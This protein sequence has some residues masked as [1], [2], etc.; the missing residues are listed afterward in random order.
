MSSALNMFP[1]VTKSLQTLWAELPPAPSPLQTPGCASAM[2]GALLTP[3]SH[4]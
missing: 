4:G 2:L 1:V 3:F